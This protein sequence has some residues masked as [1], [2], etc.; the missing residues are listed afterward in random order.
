MDLSYINELDLFKKRANAI[1]TWRQKRLPFWREV[2]TYLIPNR[3]V[4][5]GEDTT[6][7]RSDGEILTSIARIAFRTL[8][9]GLMS[10]NIPQSFKWF[11]LI[12]TAIDQNRRSLME[13]PEA[14][15]W[16]YDE[17]Q[18][19]YD[20][21][22]GT[23]FYREM[24]YHFL[25][26]AA[27]GCGLTLVELDFEKTN[28][29]T[30]CPPGSFSLGYDDRNN[31]NQVSRDVYF[32]IEQL[33]EKFGFEN[34]SETLQLQYKN[35]ERHGDVIKTI[36]YVGPNNHHV[37]GSPISAEKKYASVWWENGREDNKFL[38]RMGFDEFPFLVSE[39][40]DCPA[41][42]IMSDILQLYRMTSDKL[43][44]IEL[45][46]NPMLTGPASLADERPTLVPGKFIPVKGE[47][48]QPELRA[49]FPQG[50]DLSWISAE[51]DK[52]EAIIRKGTFADTL[53]MLSGMKDRDMTA[54]QVLELK[55]EM[56]MQFGPVQEFF[57]KMLDHNSDLTFFN[58]LK[59]G[60]VKPVPS[61]MGGVDFRP[62]YNGAMTQS[63]K[64]SGLQNIRNFVVDVAN[65]AAV[66]PA[67]LDKVNWD[68]YADILAER[69]NVPPDLVFPDEQVA[70]NR[71][72]SQAQQAELAAAKSARDQAATLKDLGT[73]QV[74]EDSLLS[75][76]AQV[77][78][79]S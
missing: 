23:N 1:E 61:V 59:L 57:N 73:T 64:T 63:Q 3:A 75:R 26:S 47:K 51:I 56:M 72:A 2:S 70:R 65:V 34:L 12:T 14:K 4:I 76:I 62:D 45:I 5:D 69:Y 40:W 58:R 19:Q 38:Q 68:Q 49:L 43:E 35:P 39:W 8:T 25:D 33:V 42:I 67:I 31:V 79:K 6:G 27:F 10:G 7:E 71:Q 50:I 37:N 36:H 54:T 13:Y 44:G 16:L 28:N 9:A 66:A 77:G 74:T 48:D 15:S 55:Q 46:N 24:P 41:F 78:A 18:A 29:Y 60:L 21:Y 11:N 52:I 17:T 53:M 20:C 22:A 32:T 30:N